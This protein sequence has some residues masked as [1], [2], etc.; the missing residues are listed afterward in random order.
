MI[1]NIIY[2]DKEKLNSLFWYHFFKSVG[3][4]TNRYSLN[5]FQKRKKVDGKYIYFISEEE[6]ALTKDKENSVFLISSNYSDSENHA[7]NRGFDF[8][9]EQLKDICKQSNMPDMEQEELENLLKVFFENR[10]WYVTWISQE[11]PKEIGPIRDN[12]LNLV[13]DASS[14]IKNQISPSDSELQY[15]RFFY[16]DLDYLSYCYEKNNYGMQ[17]ERVTSFLKETQQYYKKESMRKFYPRYAEL[18]GDICLLGSQR[19]R[20]YKS[21][22]DMGIADSYLDLKCANYFYQELQE[23]YYRKSE[24]YRIAT[25]LYQSSLNLDEENVLA[26]YYLSMMKS[27][28]DIANNSRRDYTIYPSIITEL[29]KNWSFLKPIVEK[30]EDLTSYNYLQ[31]SLKTL[32]SLK[33]F[34]LE[35]VNNFSGAN[36]FYTYTNQIVENTLRGPLYENMLNAMAADGDRS[37]LG[38]QVIKQYTKKKVQELAT[39][40]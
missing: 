16:H 14:K 13:H 31:C 11:I 2:G 27:N 36:E 3:I 35:S 7:G 28:V 22:R 39:T 19:I 17:L 29:S 23:S 4:W 15:T 40:V 12:L 26:R 9:V 20:Y 34:L 25:I 33:C 1:F 6:Q 21:V 10:I 8:Y 24:C 5:S 38:E 37:M 32:S 30:P 18:Q